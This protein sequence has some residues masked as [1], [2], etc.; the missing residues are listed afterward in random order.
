MIFF[1]VSKHFGGKRRNLVP[2]FE[3]SGFLFPCVR[4]AHAQKSGVVYNMIS[5][6]CKKEGQTCWVFIMKP[7]SGTSILERQFLPLPAGSL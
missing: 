4:I 3:S 1:L 2:L 7:L 6:S 5:F